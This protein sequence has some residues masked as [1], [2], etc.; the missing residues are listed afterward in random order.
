MKTFKETIVVKNGSIIARCYYRDE[1]VKAIEEASGMTLKCTPVSVLNS[2]LNNEEE[3]LIGPASDYAYVKQNPSTF[4]DY[5]Y[6][7]NL[8]KSDYNLVKSEDIPANDH[9]YHRPF[10]SKAAE[11]SVWDEIM[12]SSWFYDE[13]GIE[14]FVKTCYE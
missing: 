3:P 2:V 6:I 4:N 7:Y 14:L 1:L 10:K 5:G 11:K 8:V 9:G 12:R 13:T